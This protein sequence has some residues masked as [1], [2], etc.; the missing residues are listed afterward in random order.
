MEVFYTF[1][2]LQYKIFRIPPFHFL[3]MK[4]FLIISGFTLLIGTIGMA[5]F[6]FL[7]T[8]ENAQKTETLPLPESSG[9]E[10]LYQNLEEQKRN[11]AKVDATS[12]NTAIREQNIQL[13]ESITIEE[14][15]VD[16]KDAITLVQAA[17]TNNPELCN[18]LT[19]SG[20]AIKCQDTIAQHVA[21]EQGSKSLCKK[22]SDTT[23]QKNCE[24]TIDESSLRVMMES[25]TLSENGCKN[26]GTE[27][28]T[29]CFD[30]LKKN[31]DANN[32]S[33]ALASWNMVYCS[34]IT[35][36]NLKNTCS[37]SL[38]IKQAI[39]GNNQT[40]CEKIVDP[41]KKSYCLSHVS[42]RSETELFRQYVTGTDLNACTSLSDSGLKNRCHDIVT[43][44]LVRSSKDISLCQTLTNTGMT[45]SCQQVAQ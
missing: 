30:A 4:Q 16:C 12:Y 14:K 36:Q 27:Y 20:V 26:L 17:K 41:E 32:Y 9:S 7:G 29:S 10:T 18:Q 21:T 39:S 31:N 3:C 24:S 15:K 43:L 35:E 33:K 37:D 22:I 8:K 28:Q 34:I 11:Q 44:T 2:V 19:N 13:C 42:V 25:G 1:C 23:L 5:I 6:L 40:L 38:L 45:A